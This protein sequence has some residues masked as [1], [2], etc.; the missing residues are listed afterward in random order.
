MKILL[1]TNQDLGLYKFRKELIF[2]MLEKNHEVY[3]CVPKGPYISELEK[4]GCKH[5]ESKINRRGKNI[6][7]EFKLF[8][9]YYYIINKIKPDIV[10]TFTVKPNVYGGIVCRILKVPYVINM[11]GLGSAFGDKSKIQ[12]I[13]LRLYKLSL[14]DAQN[15]FFQN[16]SNL[17][18]IKQKIPNIK[19][20]LVPGSG[21]NLEEYCLLDYP[22]GEIIEFAFISRIMKEKGVEEYLDA[23]KYIKERYDNTRFHVCGY[24][25]EKNYLHELEELHKTG[26]IEF[27]GMVNDMKTIYKKIHC[28]V[29]PSYY[30]EGM[31]NV[32]LESAASGRPVITT[33]SPGCKEA[34]DD[35]ITGYIVEVK[36]VKDL[37]NKM[38]LFIEMD[39]EKRREMGLNAR[40]RVEK[41]FDRNIVIDYYLREIESVKK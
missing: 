22:D 33:D 15:V 37:I 3:A 39:N 26:V 10:L 25:E 28:L 35:G 30:K 31:S 16:E 19:T 40:K 9:S 27:H 14:A 23:A 11:S 38:I 4:F 24:C 20:K 6:F 21:V 29:H 32:I 41:Y 13:I 7:L 36:N 5:I 12:D 17:K 34:V 1:I 2:K 18:Y 8:M